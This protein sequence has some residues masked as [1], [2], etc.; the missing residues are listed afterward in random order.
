MDKERVICL[1]STDNFHHVLI[2]E[3]LDET[4]EAAGA[5]DQQFLKL[6]FYALAKEGRAALVTAVADGQ[7][8]VGILKAKSRVVNQTIIPGISGDRFKIHQDTDS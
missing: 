1:L 2:E 3:Q 7:L 8:K 4:A 5:W 6:L